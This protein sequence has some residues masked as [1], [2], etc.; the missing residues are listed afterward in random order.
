MSGLQRGTD[1]SSITD[2]I[3]TKCCQKDDQSLVVRPLKENGWVGRDVT[4]A[5]ALVRH[6]WSSVRRTCGNNDI[7]LI[8]ALSSAC[9][10]AT[11]HSRP[12]VGSASSGRV[13]I[14]VLVGS[15][16]NVQAVNSPDAAGVHPDRHLVR[17]CLAT[18]S[19]APTLPVIVV[20]QSIARPGLRK[21][22]PGEDQQRADK[23]A[24]NIGRCALMDETLAASAAN[25]A[26]SPFSQL[27]LVRPQ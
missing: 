10:P 26:D 12:A 6:P 8:L 23:P 22:E 19:S 25:S 20:R 3:V 7:I 1:C 9:L 17:L 21:V 18:N 24:T 14:R 5:F 27:V 2:P 16:Y 15:R 11:A 4:G 13:E